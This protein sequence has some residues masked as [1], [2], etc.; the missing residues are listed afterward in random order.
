MNPFQRNGIALVCFALALLMLPS[1]ALADGKFE[2]RVRALRPPVSGLELKVIEGS[3]RLELV[4]KTGATVVVKGYDDE[5]YLRFLESGVVE[6]NS[7]SPATYLNV[8]RFG[9]QEV[10]AR[11]EAGARPSWTKV[12]DDGTFTWFDHRIHLTVKRVPR[13]LRNVTRPKKVFDWEVPLTAY[14]RPVRALGTLSWDPTAPSSSSGGGFPAWI[15]AVLAALALLGVAVLVLLRR[16][17]G[18]SVTEEPEKKPAREA[19]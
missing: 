9:L 5:P 1:V 17:R 7:L 19:W 11:A 2:S 10:P 16:R 12:G 3:R 13:E 6:R 14:G 8:D 18:R 4:N 15:V